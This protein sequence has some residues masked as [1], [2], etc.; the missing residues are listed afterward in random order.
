MAEVSKLLRSFDH[1]AGGGRG[2]AHY[3]LPCGEAH[4]IWTEGREAQWTFNGDV[5]RPTFSPS[6]KH[7]QTMGGH[8]TRICHYFI[9]DGLIQYCDDCTHE[10]RGKTVEMSPAALI[11][12]AID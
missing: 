4:L 3:C 9:R 5:D 8:F 11:T 12:E 2:F 10:L 1:G 7:T 6:V